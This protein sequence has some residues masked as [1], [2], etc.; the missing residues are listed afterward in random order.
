MLSVIFLMT[1]FRD[2]HPGKG[3]GGMPMSPFLA[4][5][6]FLFIVLWFVCVDVDDAL[7]PERVTKLLSR[8][9]HFVLFFFLS[10]CARSSGQREGHPQTQSSFYSR[11]HTKSW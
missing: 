9:T 5:V 3:T 8:K 7:V 1:S 2:V 4:R 6:F 11:L 10:P